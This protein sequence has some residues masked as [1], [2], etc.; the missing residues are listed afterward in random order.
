MAL[1]LRSMAVKVRASGWH[2]IG[3]RYPPCTR[4]ETRW[5][6]KHGNPAYQ[7]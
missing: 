1:M 3:G 2:D 7:Q 6:N 5:G 4:H